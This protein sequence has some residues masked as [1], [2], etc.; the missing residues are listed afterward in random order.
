MM[1]SEN[2]KDRYLSGLGISVK[3]VKWNM[4]NKDAVSGCTHVASYWIIKKNPL[5]SS[6]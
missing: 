3:R 6:L 5:W 2:V 4:L 1:R